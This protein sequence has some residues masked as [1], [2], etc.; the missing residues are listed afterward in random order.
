[1]N[2]QKRNRKKFI[3]FISALL[4]FI[5]LGVFYKLYQ[6]ET[7]TIE[8]I[9]LNV[10]KGP[11][12][13][14]DILSQATRGQKLV[15]LDKQNDWYKIKTKEGQTGWIASWLVSET[16]NITKINLSAV[17]KKKTTLYES[18]DEKS[19][20]I[21]TIP[22]GTPVTIVAEDHFWSKVMT[23]TNQGW[24]PTKYLDLTSKTDSPKIT[25]QFLY[26]A[27]DD[28]KIRESPSIDSSIIATLNDGE[29]IRY[30][31]TDEDW[32]KVETTSGKVGYVASWVVDFNPASAQNKITSIAEATILLDPGHGGS[33]PGAHTRGED[34]YE[35]EVTLQTAKI[36]KKE[37][38]KQGARVILTREGD[39]F[40]PL[41]QIAEKSNY[42]QVNVFI[43]FHFDSSEKSN[44][45]TGTTTYFYDK[46]DQ[47]LA[48]TI[49]QQLKNR[50][51]LDNRGVEFG[52][53]Q[54]LRDN[55]QP[56]VLLELGYINNDH[57][58]YYIRTKH[59]QTQIAKAIVKGLTDYFD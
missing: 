48:E 44:S 30:L 20:A 38:E 11:G 36:V 31:E 14:Y 56:A 3:R 39:Q 16:K 43:S 54:V 40:V 41:A 23:S 28:T 8:T 45:A 52:D 25:Q 5:I 12:I 51:P 1:M 53:F 58:A 24:I 55:H 47:K 32:Y 33:D 26:A 21:R 27:Q 34:L 6:N 4:L 22:K 35:K 29:N 42:Q 49:N 10:R 18:P 13:S 50:L 15:I 7:V 57:D 37:L 9:A 46:N 19:T 17:A 2:T 59:Y